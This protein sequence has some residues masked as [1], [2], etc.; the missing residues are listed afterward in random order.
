[1]AKVQI[2]DLTFS[3][4]TSIISGGHMTTDHMLPILTELDEVGLSSIEVISP[5]SFANA[6]TTAFEDPWERMRRMRA[7]LKKTPM[8]IGF[9]GQNAMGRRNFPDDTVEYFLQKAFDNGVDIIRAADPL[10][11]TRN[12]ETTLRTAA[13]AEKKVIAGVVYTGGE[14]LKNGV[15]TLY[16]KQLEEMGA[17]AISIL[18]PAGILRPY[19][20]YQLVKSLKSTCMPETAVH[21]HTYCR[22]GMGSMTALKAA[23]AGVDT[24]YAALSPF[25]MGASLPSLETL[26]ATFTETPYATELPTEHLKT[27]AQQARH[28]YAMLRNSGFILPETG[29]IYPENLSS[30]IPSGL[31]GFLTHLLKDAKIQN[32]FTDLNAEIAKI[33]AEVGSIPLLSPVAEIVLVQAVYNLLSDNR[34]QTL[35]QEF[36]SLVNGAY[37]RTPSDI[38]SVFRN[39]ICGSPTGI[40]Y[41]P[42][43]RLEPEIS[44]LRE[45]IA[46]YSETEEDVLTY[47]MLGE[48]AKEF[49]EIRKVQK[50]RL[51]TNADFV[52]KV[53][54]V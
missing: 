49:F 30:L 13:L 54:S 39:K 40:D 3:R 41:R 11:D 2:S 12:L 47:A 44:R 20:A 34:Y 23:E 27:A 24:I 4:A 35:T 31:S 26:I 7:V 48:K 33:R 42:A 29:E 22:T 18:D 14:M 45:E 43:D 25:A 51:D 50:Y 6:V 28:L 16:A 52:N 19:D 5:A 10:N 1:M 46:T 21:L 38:Q 17:S 53:H 37:G 8:Q 15:F 9:C 36:K 32:R